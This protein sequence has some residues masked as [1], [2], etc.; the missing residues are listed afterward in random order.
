MFQTYEKKGEEP[1][2]KGKEGAP[3]E[4]GRGR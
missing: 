4:K 3:E 1:L 2:S